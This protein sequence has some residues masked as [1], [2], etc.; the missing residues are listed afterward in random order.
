M[1][2]GGIVDRPTLAL[3]GEGGEREYVIPESKMP[4]L[5]FGGINIS[6]SGGDDPRQIAAIAGAAAER[7]VLEA[8]TSGRWRRGAKGA[9]DSTLG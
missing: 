2:S 3:L 5:S 9:L 7:K 4:G 6:I 8:L 1:A